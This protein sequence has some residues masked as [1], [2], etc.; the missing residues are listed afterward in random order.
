VIEEGITELRPE[1]ALALDAKWMR[2][3]VSAQP[4]DDS[5][6]RAVQSL[7]ARS[8]AGAHYLIP[9]LDAESPE[10]LGHAGARWSTAQG[11]FGPPLRIAGVQHPAPPLACQVVRIKGAI[12]VRAPFVTA[13]LG[14]RHLRPHPPKTPSGP[15]QI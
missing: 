11:R 12:H 5:G 2:H 1:P 14:G 6:L 13:V 4:R 15:S 9:G 8:A 3:I 10:L 7:E